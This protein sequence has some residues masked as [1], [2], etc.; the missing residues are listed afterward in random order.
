MF[1]EVSDNCFFQKLY[2]I[3][4][5]SAAIM[6]IFSPNFLIK[7][8]PVGVDGIELKFI[9]HNLSASSLALYC[10]L[11]V[12]LLF[13]I[14]KSDPLSLFRDVVL[15]VFACQLLLS[16][17]SRIDIRLGDDDIGFFFD[18]FCFRIEFLALDVDAQAENTFSKLLLS[19]F[20]IPFW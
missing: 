14:L 5:F 4:S 19:L 20:L 12:A 9:S 6:F 10:V 11:F 2:I 3:F 1:G 15:G 8:V 18:F 17:L 16:F 13:L 7:V